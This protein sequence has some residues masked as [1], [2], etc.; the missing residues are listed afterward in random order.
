[1]NESGCELLPWDS[2]FFGVRIARASGERADSVRVAA[3]RE[4]CTAH[5]VDCLYFLASLDDPVTLAALCTPPFKL[6]D[7]RVTVACPIGDKS[8]EVPSSVVIREWQPRDLPHLRA[9]ASSAYTDSRFYFDQRF[10]RALCDKLYETWVEQSCRGQADFVL[11]AEHDQ[12]A[13]GFVTGSLRGSAGEIGLIGVRAQLRGRGVGTALMQSALERL[14][15]RGCTQVELVTQGRNIGAQRMYQRLGFVT[16]S[17]KLW[18]HGWFSQ[19]GDS[20]G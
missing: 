10:E 13:A 11:V 17:I 12:A 6:V 19:R 14:R 20:I 8:Y 1:M 18:F 15:L 5:Q 9:I 7:L 16:Q 2:E 3:I 4:W